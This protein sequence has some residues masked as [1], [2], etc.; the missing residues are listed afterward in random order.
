MAETDIKMVYAFPEEFVCNSV[1]VPA[2]RYRAIT[3]QTANIQ[4]N[5]GTD[6]NLVNAVGPLG[7]QTYRRPIISATVVGSAYQLLASQSGSIC[8]NDRAAGIVWTLPLAQVGLEFTFH[9]T[10]TVTSNSY[11]VITAA[12]TELLVGA[13]NNV[14]TDTSSAV[15]IWQSLAATSN[16]AVTQQA[17]GTNATGGIAG[18]TLVF[19]CLSSTRW[20]VNGMTLAGGTVATPFATS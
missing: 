4:E 3:G 13:I 1:T 7:Q 2:V 20:A 14:D 6:G 9:T 15:A 19:T 10:V 18:S 12:G 8:L 16:I 5:Y 11:K 17:A